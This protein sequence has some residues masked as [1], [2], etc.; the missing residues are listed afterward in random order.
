MSSGR[1]RVQSALRRIRRTRMGGH[2]HPLR[3]T[4]MSVRK[5]AVVL[6]ILAMLLMPSGW[7]TRPICWKARI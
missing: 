4:G 6:A 1:V 7:D 3:E 2:P 5:I